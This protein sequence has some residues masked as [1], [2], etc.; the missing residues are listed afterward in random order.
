LDKKRI[1]FLCCI[2]AATACIVTWLLTTVYFNSNTKDTELRLSEENYESISELLDLNDLK[3]IIN[4]YYYEE[5]DEQVLIDGALKG[6]VAALNDPYSFYYPEEEYNEYNNVSDGVFVGIGVSIMQDENTGY[7]SVVSVVDESPASSG[8]IMIGDTIKAVDGVDVSGMSTE[9]VIDII[10]GPAGSSVKLTLIR[11]DGE[12]VIDLVRAEVR[13]QFVFYTMYDNLC[14]IIIEEFHGDVSSDFEKAIQFAYDE[15]ASG[16]ILDIRSNLGGSVVEATEIAD[17][18]LPE[19][20][21]V[22]TENRE[23]ERVEYTSDQDMCSLPMV[24]L[25]NEASASASEILAGALQDHDRAEIVGRQTYGK[26]VVQTVLDM[27][28]SGGGVKLTSSVYF[29]PLGRSINNIGIT[30]DYDVQL[31]ESVLNGEEKLSFD[32]DAQLA[33]A[34]EVLKEKIAADTL[35]AP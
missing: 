20:L 18:I 31:P 32:T 21:I 13:E 30:P 11:D 17:N 22:Y 4:D 12:V 34:I 14:Y 19:C 2:I 9:E 27:P 23:G 5:V 10:K 1:V 6:M 15:G 33:K 26:G 29:T 28:Y 25:V 8:G 16:I 35:A 3:G 24:V 7:F